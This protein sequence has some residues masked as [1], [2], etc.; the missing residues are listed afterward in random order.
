MIQVDGTRAHAGAKALQL[1]TPVG[2]RKYADIIKQNPPDKEL[3]PI[4]HYGRVMVWVTTLPSAAH[5]NINQA[6]GPLASNPQL[7]AKYSFGGQNAVL[8]PNYTQRAPA[9]DGLTPLRGGR[10]G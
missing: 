1:T 10:P 5:W 2:G 7:I 3:L 4:K 9:G 6:G 8:S